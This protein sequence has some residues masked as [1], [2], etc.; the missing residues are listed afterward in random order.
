MTLRLPLVVYAPAARRGGAL[1]VLRDA[2][3]LLEMKG[4]PVTVVTTR[5]AA[6]SLMEV[7]DQRMVVLKDGGRLGQLVEDF[8]MAP[9]LIKQMYPDGARVICLSNRAVRL[10]KRYVQHVLV[11]NPFAILRQTPR[12]IT[13]TKTTLFYTKFYPSLLTTNFRKRHFYYVQ[14]PSLAR[15]LRQNYSHVSKVRIISPV[16]SASFIRALEEPC[17]M[18]TNAKFVFC[19]LSANPHKNLSLLAKV[20]PDLAQEGLR[21]V[22]TVTPEEWKSHTSAGVP[23]GVDCIGRIGMNEMADYYRT[24]QAMIFPSLL[25]TA[26]LPL[27]EAQAAGCKIIAS[28]MDFTHDLLAN[29]PL[30]TVFDPTQPSAL[31]QAVRF[32]LFS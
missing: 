4:H 19:P 13:R 25:E 31:I 7:K 15:H 12:G 3:L 28:D 32:S 8:V 6:D 21:I 9:R 2:L 11:H 22:V 18:S 27:L 30:L 20:A 17:Q 29:S 23:S 14:R 1:T 26:G 16:V 24:A 10:G 5:E